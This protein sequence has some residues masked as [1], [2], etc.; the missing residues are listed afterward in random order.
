MEL[1]KLGRNEATP[2]GSSKGPDKADLC[3]SIPKQTTP[4]NPIKGAKRLDPCE[5]IPMEAIPLRLPESSS[6]AKEESHLMQ[7]DTLPRLPQNSRYEDADGT[8]LQQDKW[9]SSSS[10]H[11]DASAEQVCNLD[12]NEALLPPPLQKNSTEPE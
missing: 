8:Q 7:N 6:D 1:Y 12:R 9:H 10:S 5:L 2:E 11:I 3:Q 4:D